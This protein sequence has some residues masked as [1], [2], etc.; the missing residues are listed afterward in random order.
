MFICSF[1]E[2]NKNDDGWFVHTGLC[3]TCKK[4][5]DL[6]KIYSMDTL[7][8]SLESIYIREE[9]PIKKRTDAIAEGIELRSSKKNKIITI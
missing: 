8:T 5:K 6:S 2:N 1:C 3:S 7:L 9:T 4:V